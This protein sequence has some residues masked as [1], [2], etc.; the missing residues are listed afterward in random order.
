MVSLVQKLKE[1]KSLCK[2][3]LTFSQARTF[4]NELRSSESDTLHVPLNDVPNSDEFAEDL[5]Q[6]LCEE[7]HIKRLCLK[8]SAK[9]EALFSRLS[10]NFEKTGVSALELNHVNPDLAETFFKRDNLK[11]L[12]LIDWGGSLSRCASFLE[13]SEKLETLGIE[14]DIYSGNDLDA[15]KN[16]MPKN[17]KN[18]YLWFLSSRTNVPNKDVIDALPDLPRL[19]TLSLSMQAF[20]EDTISA[21]KP[22]IKNLKCLNLDYY[23]HD[24]TSSHPAC[25]AKALENSSVEE[26]SLPPFNAGWNDKNINALLDLLE[27]PSFTVA[28][29]NRPDKIDCLGKKN[30]LSVETRQRIE[31][32]EHI[33]K[34]IT[35]PEANHESAPKTQQ[36]DETERFA[37]WFKEASANGDFNKIY[38][39]LAKENKTLN[40]ED[41]KR[42]DENGI[43]LI[44]ALAYSK[45]LDKVF[46]PRHWNNAKDMQTVFDLLSDGHKAQLDGKDG[47]P[48]FKV[49]KNQ[50]MAKAVRRNVTVN[51]SFER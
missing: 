5:V 27:A 17:L 4:V 19:E 22:H 12:Q 38:D 40:V 23:C 31:R 10:E 14:T 26:L 32:L 39:K 25:L 28:K 50:V 37:D 6:K 2:Q 34:G 43:C 33:K 35:H 9:R 46:S 41:Y 48:N 36:P 21:L 20:N 47:R 1:V 49:L 8:G 51:K 45:Q 16:R 18:F 11:E 7:P 13:K 44:H 3:G 42:T 29:L 30:A 24:D 15:L